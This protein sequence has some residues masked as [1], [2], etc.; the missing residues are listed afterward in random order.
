VTFSDRRET[1]VRETSVRAATGDVV[2]TTDDDG[3]PRPD[4]L[5]AVLSRYSHDDVGGVGGRDL[6]RD[7]G[8]VVGGTARRVGVLQP[9]GRV[10]GNHH[11]GTGPARDVDVL[12][13]VNMSMRRELWRFDRSL[14]GE[15][16]QPHW[17]LD[18]CL[19]ARREGWRLIYDPGIVVDHHRAPRVGEEAR[20][21]LTTRSLIDWVHNELYAVL[22]W[23]PA[24]RRAVAIAYALL[25]GQRNTPGP[26]L[27]PERLVRERDVGEVLRRSRA[28]AR[29]RLLALRN[30]RAYRRAQ[31]ARR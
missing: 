2:A 24:R 31:R 27:I 26:L 14:R 12:K 22:K 11:I 23:A 6:M 28:G 9:F 7:D 3:E 29:A 16:T 15:G 19:R 5:A 21:A 25:V 4:W 8:A 20:S 17:E 1:N 30:A 10:I 18:L 13:G